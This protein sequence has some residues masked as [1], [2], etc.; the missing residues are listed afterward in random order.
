MCDNINILHCCTRIATKCPLQ[1]CVRIC[2]SVRVCICACA[3]AYVPFVQI[4]IC[5]IKVIA[6]LVGFANVRS[7]VFRSHSKLTSSIA[8][9]SFQVRELLR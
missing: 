3:C 8:S 4:I 6:I 9:D 7:R 5:K 1:L 2:P